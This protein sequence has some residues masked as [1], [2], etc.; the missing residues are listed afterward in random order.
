MV[1]TNVEEL[2]KYAGLPPAFFALCDKRAN[3]ITARHLAI[4]DDTDGDDIKCLEKY[5]IPAL[6]TIVLIRK[7]KEIMINGKYFLNN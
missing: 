2:C 4:L 5:G 6:F 1:D 3:C 7:S